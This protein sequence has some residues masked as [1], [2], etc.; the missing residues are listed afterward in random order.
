MASGR[1]VN[2]GLGDTEKDAPE[3]TMWANVRAVKD[4]MVGVC[5][6]R[7]SA[8]LL[9]NFQFYVDAIISWINP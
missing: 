7:S 1:T 6:K 4:F 3:V 5:H 2:D 9:K 8:C